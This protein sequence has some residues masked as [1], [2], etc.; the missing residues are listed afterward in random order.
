MAVTRDRQPLIGDKGVNG[1]LRD[2]L[3]LPGSNLVQSGHAANLF[4]ELS[5][6]LGI[7]DTGIF[8]DSLL[9]GKRGTYNIAR[10]A[11]RSKYGGAR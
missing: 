11:M 7:M 5:Y 4:E 1:L 6:E 9:S 10:G 8:K 3:S 2:S